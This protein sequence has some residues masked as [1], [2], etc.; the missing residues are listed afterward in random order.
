M[1]QYEPMYDSFNRNMRDRYVPTS[2]MSVSASVYLPG[3]DV[4]MYTGMVKPDRQRRR[5]TQG[6][7]LEA[8]RLEREEKRLQ[9]AIRR[10]ESKG[11]VRIPVRTGILLMAILMF[12]CG[13]VLLYHQGQIFEHQEQIK[14]LDERIAKC[15]AN[16]QALQE[17]I[18]EASSEA[19]ICYYA[20]QN[21]GMVPDVSI[22][23]IHLTAADTRPVAYVGAQP[24][25][26]Q[27]VVVSFEAQT[28]PVPML[29]SN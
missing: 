22:S 29:A 1:S 21:L 20:A 27:E 23:A 28:T 24:A 14:K 18:D 19:V 12:L 6:K 16:N 5:R 26:Q 3:S 9:E 2:R 17:Q 8:E 7:R 10:E 13:S 4:D 15:R 11:G 25:Q